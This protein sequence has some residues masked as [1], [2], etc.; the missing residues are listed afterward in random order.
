MNMA[1]NVD[2]QHTKADLFVMKDTK[3]NT[4]FQLTWFY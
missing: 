4:K 3:C 2:Y 1:Y